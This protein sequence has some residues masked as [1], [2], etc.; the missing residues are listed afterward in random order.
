[1]HDS[2]HVGLNKFDAT[3]V[4]K[5][6]WHSGGFRGRRAVVATILRHSF[7]WTRI[8]KPQRKLICRPDRT[9]AQGRGLRNPLSNGR[10]LGG[11]LVSRKGAKAQSQDRCFTLPAFYLGAFAPWREKNEGI[12]TLGVR[13]TRSA[14]WSGLTGGPGVS[15]RQRSGFSFREAKTRFWIASC[16]PHGMLRVACK[17]PSFRK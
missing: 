10:T 16:V 3:R 13:V 14:R 12:D 8:G 4:G 7:S 17:C 2:S 11:A 15:G 5:A 1:M 6:G 9:R